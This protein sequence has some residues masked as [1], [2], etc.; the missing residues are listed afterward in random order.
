MVRVHGVAVCG[1]VFA[2]YLKEGRFFEDGDTENLEDCVEPGLEIEAFFD[3]GD[4]NVHRDGDPDL[5]F[6]SVLG[7]AE[8]AL[9]AQ[10][11]LD[12]F[13]EQFDLPAAFVEFGDGRSN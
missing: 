8:E 7:S 13:E 10:V 11:L 1:F 9:D 4:E 2:K 12:P 5:G 3:D 6:D